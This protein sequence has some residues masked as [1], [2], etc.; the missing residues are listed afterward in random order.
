[1]KNIKTILL[2]LFV[3]LFGILSAQKGGAYTIGSEVEN[4]ALMNVDNTEVSL[5]NYEEGEGVIVVFTCNHC[6]YAKKYE[7]RI[8]DLHAKFKDKGYP[9]I[10]INPND[11]EVQPEDGFE[12]MKERAQQK[13]YKFPYLL[14]EGQRVYPKFGATK[15]PHVFVLKKEN[16][17]FVV[18]Y[19]G[20]IDNNYE[21]PADV[22]ERYVEDAVHS[23]LEGKPIKTTKTVAIG[24]T[25]KKKK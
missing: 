2:V 13:N 1:M 8:I 19:I 9:V 23:L 3:G 16:S 14:D 11:P 20:A 4:F 6:P 22:S 25:I 24:C 18:K 15:T 5:S 7:D 17:K 10:A 21:N 12:Q